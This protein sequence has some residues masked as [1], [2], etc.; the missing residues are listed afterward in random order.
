MKDPTDTSTTSPT[1]RLRTCG[2]CFA[3][4]G[5]HEAGFV[6]TSTGERLCDRCFE[7][8]RLDH[9]LDKLRRLNVSLARLLLR[10]VLETSR[11]A[12]TGTAL[13]AETAEILDEL[14]LAA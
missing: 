9:E 5:D 13:A 8:A 10:H 3:E 6:N 14:D 7:I 11:S 4:L 2:V 12:D 1:A